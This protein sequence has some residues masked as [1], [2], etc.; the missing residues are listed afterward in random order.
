MDLHIEAQRRGFSII[1]EWKGLVEK[2]LSQKVKAL[3]TDNSD[4]FKSVRTVIA[5]AV[6]NGLKL[7]Q[8][9]V[10]TC[11][12]N[13][14][15]REEVYMKQQEGFVTMGQEHLVCRLKQS[16]YGLK[17]A[18]RCWNVVLNKR[19]KKMGFVQTDSDRRIYVSTE[20]EM[21]VIAVH[22]GDIV[23]AT[24]SD[25]RMAEVKRGLPEGFEVK[26]MG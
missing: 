22:V 11:F 17:Q 16:I 18:S 25:K 8:M 13:G 20:G 5:L 24:K 7:Y 3:R 19:L 26:D 9:D 23:L 15:L 12:L 21:F 6:Q 10:A 2:S 1:L 14:E 4:A